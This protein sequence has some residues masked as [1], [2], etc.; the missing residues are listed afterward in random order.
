M[1]LDMLLYMLQYQQNPLPFEAVRIILAVVGT[2]IGAYYDIWNNKN[3]PNAYLY[4]FLAAAL[5]VNLIA[6]D[7]VLSVYG[8]ASAALIFAFTWALYKAGQL[9]GADGYIMASIVMLLPV[10]PALLL[11]P[12]SGVAF[13]IPFALNI[14]LSSGLFFMAYMLLRSLPVAYNAMLAPK[15]IPTN[16]WMGAGLVLAVFAMMSYL[17]TSMPFVPPNLYAFITV[18]VC[19]LIYLVLFKKAM[20]D[21]M[22]EWVAP[23]K[24]EEEDILAV[25]HLGPKYASS[26]PRLVDKAVLKKILSLKLKKVPVYKHLPPFIPHIFAGL[27]LALLIGNI[28]LFITGNSGML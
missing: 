22:V 1:A 23:S 18:V 11:P 19:I 24:V 8:I 25:E 21:S 4:G 9:G 28:V 17:I 12:L 26:I 27:A 7:P 5:I 20:N 6:F 13:E 3:I 10:Q 14:V 2:A 16:A 15:S